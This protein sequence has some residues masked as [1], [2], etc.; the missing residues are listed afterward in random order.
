MK[1]TCHTDRQGFLILTPTLLHSVRMEY[2]TIETQFL[3]EVANHE[4]ICIWWHA[5]LIQKTLDKYQGLFGVS[6]GVVLLHCWTTSE[7]QNT[8]FLTMK[9]SGRK[10]DLRYGNA[11]C[12]EAK[13][14]SPLGIQHGS[15]NTLNI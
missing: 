3:V 10:M 11:A 15:S 8:S 1:W 2:C 12:K 5:E 6:Q 7:V 14:L 9:L 13:G 4:A